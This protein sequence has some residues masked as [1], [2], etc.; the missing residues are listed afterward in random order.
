MGFTVTRQ[1]GTK[2]AEFQAY[3]RLLRQRGINLGKLPRVPEPGTRRRWLYVWSDADEA[4]RFADDLKERTTDDAWQVVETT[5]PPS[6]GPLGPVLIQLARR[7]DGLLF[8][9]HPLSRAMIQSAFPQ[10][11]Q[12]AT[13]AFLA[14]QQWS[15]FRRSHGGLREL[16]QQIAPSLTGLTL[17][18]L[19]DV[20]YAVMD[21]DTEDTIVF[22]PPAHVNQG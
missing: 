22:V 3:V 13:N 5:A 12:S 8:A 19:E 14:T 17:E 9:L 2:D 16:V 6:E 21:T 15:D 1:G 20:G 10:A 18:Q 4:Q 11:M 7:G